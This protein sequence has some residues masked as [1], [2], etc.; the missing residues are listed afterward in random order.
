MI[1]L[2]KDIVKEAQ[3]YADNVQAQASKTMEIQ[4]SLLKKQLATTMQCIDSA[5]DR[6]E[7]LA[8]DGNMDLSN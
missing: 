7:A 3:E 6:L 5:A 2:K 4:L 8:I 1:T